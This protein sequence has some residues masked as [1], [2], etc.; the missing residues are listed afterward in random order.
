MIYFSLMIIS[1]FF[2]LFELNN[3]KIKY[4]SNIP[5]IMIAIIFIINKSN[6]DY[7]AY[8]TFY[9][10]A[11]IN[12][13]EI[14]WGFLYLM[15]ILKKVGFHY[16]IVPT[17]IGIILVIHLFLN[18]NKNNDNSIIIFLYSI[19]F[20]VYDLN[21]IRNLLMI[22][23]IYLGI[24][25]KKNYYLFNI[26]GASFHKFG[27]I[28]LGFGFLKKFNL[29]K[30][31]IT[32]AAL[33]LLGLLLL[34]VI[35]FISLKIFPQKMAYYYASPPNLGFLI[36]YIM[37]GIDLFV[38]YFIQGY[39]NNTELQENYLKFFLFVIII[40]PFSV[41]SLQIIERTYRNTF[42]IK[43]IFIT[44]KLKGRSLSEKIV[45]FLIMIVNAML[46]LLLSLSSDFEW[47]VNLLKSIG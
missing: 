32:V 3:K 34:P 44:Q 1:L 41:L 10:F 33:F 40:L 30:Y 24:K 12:I 46:P 16:Q 6:F 19:Y 21:Q 14:D 13:G 37:I 7:S 26:L 17:V 5:I 29:K 31:I 35:K 20:F 43:N 42:L 38:I 39:K 9:D 45:L 4:L 2:S 23:M 27:I 11:P 25:Y 18:S 22:I 28:Y 47:T 8:E 36:Y 15:T